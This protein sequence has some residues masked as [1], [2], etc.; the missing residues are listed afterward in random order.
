MF[1]AYFKP[2][3]TILGV[4]DPLEE[5][6][7]EKGTL[8]CYETLQGVYR[9]QFLTQNTNFGL[10]MLLETCSTRLKIVFDVLES[11]TIRLTTFKLIFM[12][13]GV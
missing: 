2:L 7:W 9:S 6:S 11:N 3:C 12:T 1:F 8:G 13:L 5:I 10:K 4:L